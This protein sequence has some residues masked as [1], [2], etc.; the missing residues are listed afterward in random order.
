MDAS[1]SASVSSPPAGRRAQPGQTLAEAPGWRRLLVAVA[2]LMARSGSGGSERV[3]LHQARVSERIEALIAAPAPLRAPAP[4]RPP[5]VV[6]ALPR[7]IARGAEGPAGEVLAAVEA[8]SGALVW[9]EGYVR[10]PAGLHARFAQCEIAAAGGPVVCRG[11][12]LGLILF[13]PGCTYPMH[14]HPGVEESYAC[15]AGAVSQN[16]EGVW[17]PGA[18]IVNR[19]GQLHRLTSETGGPSLLAYAWL[20]PGP[21]L[22]HA[23][24]RFLRATPRRRRDET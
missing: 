17:T 5:A 13:A 10:P 2:E 12:R 11:M 20:G 3:R 16:E 6:R 9:R 18:M 19:P 21:R 14:A 15:L 7:A 4:A 8:V 1:P 24:T 22:A 23:A